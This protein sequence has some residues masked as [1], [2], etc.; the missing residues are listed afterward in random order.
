MMLPRRNFLRLAAGAAALLPH[1]ARAQAYPN[2]YVRFVVPFPPGAS[3]DPVARIIANRL[4][5]VWGQQ[6]VIDNKGGAGGNLAAQNVAQSPPDGYTMLLSAPS[7]ATNGYI[8][9]SLGFDPVKDFAPV[10]L[11]CIFPTLITVPNS[12]PARTLGDFIAYA[13]A[14]PGT[15]TYGTPGIGLP[16]HLSAELL[17]RM[18]GIEW[19]VVPYRG[20][21]PALNDLIPG[22][23]S[24]LVSSL[25][26]ML[27]HIRSGTIR[28]LAVTSI[29]RSPFAPDIPT[30]AE[31]GFPGF[32]AVGWYGLFVHARTPPAI[33]EKI[34]GDVVA[35]I[36]HPS[37]SQ[38]FEDIFLETQ[39][40]TPAELAAFLKSEMEKWGPI[41]QASGIKPE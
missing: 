21:G 23:I 33:L 6:V 28:G 34:H 26:G 24:S 13:R 5:E 18:A 14:N 31:S 30:I 37:V 1:A 9:P 17:K 35:A 27:P 39:T 38:K 32:D 3:A 8:Y 22:R 4:S 36:K 40:G 16:S 10:T 41:V 7:L 12:S 15:V 29:A 2:R 11:I 19:T 20:A 25:P